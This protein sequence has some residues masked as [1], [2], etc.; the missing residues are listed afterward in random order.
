[1]KFFKKNNAYTFK[2]KG[3][4]M[5]ELVVVMAIIAILTLLAIPSIGRYLE[6]TRQKGIDTAAATIHTVTRVKL[7]DLDGRTGTPIS[8]YDSDSNLY[9]EIF[10][11]SSLSTMDSTLVI[12]SYQF[13]AL[14][15][16]TT[17]EAQVHDTI[18]NNAIFTN[19]VVCLPNHY[20]TASDPADKINLDLEYP[21]I[22]FCVRDGVPTQIYNN[23]LN[24]T[25]TY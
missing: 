8:I 25:D 15:N 23:G 3:F 19:W 4:S 16:T 7:S 18:P 10:R 5:I 14:P 20:L 2:N 22:I 11:G 21:I 1:M 13:D 12:Q 6:Q 17:I 9:N 24:V